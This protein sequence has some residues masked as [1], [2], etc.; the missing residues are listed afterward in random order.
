[1]DGW[2]ITVRWEV[3]YQGIGDENDIVGRCWM[4]FCK[5]AGRF[6]N[7]CEVVNQVAIEELELIS[8]MSPDDGI[9]ISEYDRGLTLVVNRNLGAINL[10]FG[11]CRCG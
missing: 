7:A 10:T 4:R 2:G 5:V 6:E 1:M 3:L 11:D 9:G 8:K